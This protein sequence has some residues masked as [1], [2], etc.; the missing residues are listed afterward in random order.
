MELNAQLIDG[1]EV[2]ALQGRF[3]VNVASTVR[4]RID[5]ITSKKPALLVVNLEEVNFLDSTGLATLVQGQKQAQAL[6]G[7][8]NLC[9]LRQS[10]RIIFELT[11][12]DS[13]FEIF[14]TEEEAVTALVEMKLS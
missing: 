6:N 8:M 14:S 3:D 1:I 9:G 2:I 5:D 13:F 4:K 12:L 10:V 11:R 7:K